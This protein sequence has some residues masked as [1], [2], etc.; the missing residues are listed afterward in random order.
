MK[1]ES[2]VCAGPLGIDDWRANCVLPSSAHSVET[3]RCAAMETMILAQRRR[4]RHRRGYYLLAVYFSWGRN[5][6][7]KQTLRCVN[8]SACGCVN[9]SLA[10]KY[11]YYGKYRYCGKLVLKPFLILSIGKYRSIDIFDNTI[12]YY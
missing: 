7:E 10:T 12:L 8:S 1:S 4:T 9:N 11:R 5:F 3:L 6:N 2:D